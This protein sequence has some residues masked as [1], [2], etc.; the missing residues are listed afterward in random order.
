MLFVNR[1]LVDLRDRSVRVQSRVLEPKE[2][3]DHSGVPF[4]H[5]QARVRLRDDC[6]K[7]RTE[8]RFLDDKRDCEPSGELEEGVGVGWSGAADDDHT[9]GL[10][11]RNTNSPSRALSCK[12]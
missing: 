2:I 7:R 8:C 10:Y 12:R 11:L 1:H 6:L 4:G 5:K 3:T 9:H